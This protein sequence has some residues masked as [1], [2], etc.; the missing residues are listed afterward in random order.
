MLAPSLLSRPFS[1]CLEH[2]QSVC[3]G[4]GMDEMGWGKEKGSCLK[5]A[6]EQKQLKCTL[7]I[8]KETPIL[9]LCHILKLFPKGF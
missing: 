5:E 1:Q 2:A 3:E 8:Y 6:A 4:W 9:H 7:V